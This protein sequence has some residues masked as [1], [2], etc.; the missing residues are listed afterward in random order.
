MNLF[1]QVKLDVFFVGE[2]YQ[3][4]VTGKSPLYINN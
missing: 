2:K 3:E 1:S 4:K